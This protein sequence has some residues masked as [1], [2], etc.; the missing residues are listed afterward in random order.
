VAADR[1][2]SQLQAIYRQHAV[3][4]LAY[5]EHFTGHE[6]A[7]DAVQ[8][9]FLRAWH[10]LPRLQLDPR[11]VRPW[12]TLVLRRV[13]TDAHRRNR[14]YAKAQ[15]RLCDRP[16]SG[17]YDRVDDRRRLDQALRRLS[18]SHRHVLMQIYYC[19]TPINRVAA[20]LG[21]PAGTVRSRLHYA[22]RR[23]RHHLDAATP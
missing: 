13:L 9:T 11:P 5:A 2:A 21:I 1:D 10:H 23:L 19:D 17:D 14:V 16:V 7:E 3:A 12:L 15:G 6:A 20:D 22:V 8:E 18:P 4:L